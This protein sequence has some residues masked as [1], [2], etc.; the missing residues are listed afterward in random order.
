MTEELKTLKCPYCEWEGIEAKQFNVLLY[1]CM[2]P[3]CPIVYWNPLME[4]IE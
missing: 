3:M 4:L 2:N 1:E